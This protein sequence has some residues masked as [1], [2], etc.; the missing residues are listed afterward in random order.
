MCLYLLCSIVLGLFLCCAILFSYYVSYQKSFFA[1]YILRLFYF[2]LPV[3]SFLVI[4]WSF[5]SRFPPILHIYI[6]IILVVTFLIEC[7]SS[8]ASRIIRTFLI[9]IISFSSSVGHFVFK[10]L[11][12][13]LL[14]SSVRYPRSGGVQCPFAILLVLTWLL[15]VVKR[16]VNALLLYS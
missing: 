9:I 8:W 3:Q 16:G 15:H 2:I 7:S 5:L 14:K 1:C 4:P 13:P 12:F 6:P 11:F 10:N